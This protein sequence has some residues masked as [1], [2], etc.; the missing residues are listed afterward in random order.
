M[1]STK[2]DNPSKSDSKVQGEGD[3][4]AARRYDEA[5]RGFAQSG[6]VEPAARKAAPRDAQE[7]K[8]IEKAE[9][10]GKSRSKGEDSGDGR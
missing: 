2:P 7:A 9:D 5:A 3:Y 1:G 4:E 10:I 8:D 6:K